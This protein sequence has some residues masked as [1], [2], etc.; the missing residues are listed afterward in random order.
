[1]DD[2]TNLQ[3]KSHFFGWFVIN[4]EV[5]RFIGV[6]D[7]IWVTSSLKSSLGITCISHLFSEHALDFH[8]RRSEP[9][10]SMPYLLREHFTCSYSIKI[11][12]M[13]EFRLSDL[14]VIFLRRFFA[15]FNWFNHSRIY[16]S[17]VKRVFLI[18][19][20]RSTLNIEYEWQ[21]V[22]NDWESIKINF[23]ASIAAAI[24]FSLLVCIWICKRFAFFK[25]H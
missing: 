21:T 15:C 5:S 2:L 4:G 8:S 14:V 17:D 13:Y 10:D 9:R 22:H 1:M 3:K 12:W 23:I 7:V 25:S 18:L 16:F 24:E 11:N 19:E 20:C 6:V